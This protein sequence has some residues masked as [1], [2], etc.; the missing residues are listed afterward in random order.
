M[1]IDQV[2]ERERKKQ[3]QQEY[4]E[5][6]MECELGNSFI[7]STL[8]PHAMLHYFTPRKLSSTYTDTRHNMNIDTLTLLII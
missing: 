7:V 6:H 4:E 8:L 2:R 5:S 3:R 1:M